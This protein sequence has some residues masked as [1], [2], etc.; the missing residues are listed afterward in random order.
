MH[1]DLTDLTDDEKRVIGALKRLARK[2]PMTLWLY[3]ASGS[4]N[5]MRC[6]SEGKHAVSDRGL[7]QH[8]G[9]D[10]AYSITVIDIPNDGGDW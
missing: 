5:V 6:N 4:L 7:D 1:H 9:V 10:P 2:W 8:G 3:S